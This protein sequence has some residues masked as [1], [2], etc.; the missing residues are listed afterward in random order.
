[1]QG[2]RF[3]RWFAAPVLAAF[4]VAAGAQQFTMKLSTVTLNDVTHEWMKAFKAGVEARAGNRI[5][6]EI[7][8]A[9]QLG[10]LPRVIEGVAMGT[11]E[12]TVPTPGFM[13]GMEPRYLVLD[14]PALFDNLIHGHQVLGDPELRKRFATFGA[15]RG[16]EPLFLF[17]NGPAMLLSHKPVRSVADLKGQKIRVP[18]GAPMHV[19]PFKRLGV[20]PLSVA[21]GEVLPAMQNRAID[22]LVSGFNVLTAFKFYDVAKTVTEL[23]ASFLGAIGLVNRNFMKSLG[24]ELEAIVRE[25]SLKAEKLFWTWG[26]DDLARIQADWEKN[27]GQVIKMAPADAQRYIDEVTSVLPPLLAAN[28]QLKEDYEAIIAT[29]KKYRK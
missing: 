2:L 27:G 25:E 4:A 6:V 26:I 3:V 29:A 10:P 18:G 13:V 28:P 19:E 8:P 22:G 24:P 7:Y 5:K 14:T 9:S 16:V 20:A 21:L 1:M 17:L 15:A 12:L 23:P 11:V